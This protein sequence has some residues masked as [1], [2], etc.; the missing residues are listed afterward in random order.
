MSPCC[1]PQIGPGCAADKAVETCVCAVDPFC[2]DTLWD[3]NCADMVAGEGCGSCGSSEGAKI[4]SF[5]HAPEYVPGSPELVREPLL[6]TFSWSIEN[7]G[8]ATLKCTLSPGD[9]DGLW[10]YT[11]QDCAN[12][13]SQPHTYWENSLESGTYPAVLAINGVDSPEASASV[14]VTV[15]GNPAQWMG[16]TIADLPVDQLTSPVVRVNF[17]TDGYNPAGGLGN[18]DA[19]T[20]YF[21][22]RLPSR[23]DWE[24]SP[25]TANVD[26]AL[27]LSRCET[28]QRTVS[29]EDATISYWVDG[30]YMEGV[31]ALI[32]QT[33]QDVE[34]LECVGHTRFL[35]MWSD[36]DV[37]IEIEEMCWG[38][39]HC[40]NS[41]TQQ[42]VTAAVRRKYQMELRMGWNRLALVRDGYAPGVGVLNEIIV[43]EN[44]ADQVPGGFPEDVEL[45]DWFVAALP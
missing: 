20:R 22:D 42:D 18:I 31:N 29:D 4:T 16:G 36:R 21:R 41:D 43:T 15:L 23:P 30:V 26:D 12:T 37:S 35:R 10:P 8:G 2:C 17:R 32:Y 13:T 3:Q 1:V 40:F 33:G 9:G 34:E 6:V 38:V 24:A 14:D 7:P 11:V 19:P 25:W 28:S 27:L 39:A 5:T 44:R 45:P